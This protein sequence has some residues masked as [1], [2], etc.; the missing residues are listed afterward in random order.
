VIALLRRNPAFR[1]LWFSQVVSQ[2]GSWLNRVAVLALIGAIGEEKEAVAV[3]A[4]YGLE[5]ALRMLPTAFFGPVAGALA[6]RLPRRMLMVLA[7]LAQGGLVLGLLSVRGPDDMPVLYALVVLQMGVS[8]FFEA[9]RSASVPNTVAADDLLAANALSAATWSMM[10]TVG[11]VAGGLLVMLVGVRGVFVVDALTFATSAAILIGVRLPAVPAHP[12]AFSWPD[13]FLLADLRRG[14]AHVRERGLLPVVLAKSFWGAAG[15]YLVLLSIAGSERFGGGPEAAGLAIGV[16]FCAR[17]VGTGIGPVLASR[18]FR[19]SDRSLMRQIAGCFALAAGGYSLFATAETLA[20]AFA[21]VA[22]AHVGG[23]T[24]WVASTT[25]WQRH[26]D[27]AFR[28]RVFALEF[29]GMTLVFAA[30]GYLTGL[31]FDRTGSIARTSW[32]V[33]AAVLFSGLAWYLFARRTAKSALSTPS[34]IEKAG[35][36]AVAS[37]REPTLM[38]GS[39]PDSWHSPDVPS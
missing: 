24:L 23:S 32:T 6:D 1:R 39:G 38:P 10:L 35:T 33:S 20:G 37:E 36:V 34:V 30:F 3:G 29:S 14:L 25:L 15:G 21:C 13:F 26:V 17:G 18:L 16:L 2:A 7:D 4:L 19:S 11:S 8:V 31:E 28:G 27:D 12:D 9:A 22:L 5:L